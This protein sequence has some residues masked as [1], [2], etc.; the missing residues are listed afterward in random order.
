M[1]LHCR[2]V[3]SW[4]CYDARLVCLD[5]RAAFQGGASYIHCIEHCR[6]LCHAMLVFWTSYPRWKMIKSKER[7]LGCFLRISLVAVPFVLLSCH[8]S[9]MRGLDTDNLAMQTDLCAT[10]FTLQ[11]T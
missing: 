9:P 1:Q 8:V 6:Y 5:C 10:P 2:I 3:V 7:I 4:I 11:R